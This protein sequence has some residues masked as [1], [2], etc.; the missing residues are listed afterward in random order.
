MS[1]PGPD[2]EFFSVEPDPNPGEK[3]MDTHSSSLF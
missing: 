3:M 1:D 2:P